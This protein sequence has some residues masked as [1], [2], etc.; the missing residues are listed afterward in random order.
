MRSGLPGCADPPDRVADIVGDQQ[1]AVAGDLDADRA[2]KALPPSM[3]PVRTL[4]GM[5]DGWPPAKGTK[6]TW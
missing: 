3:K 5:P 4:I 1:R 2:A 6:T